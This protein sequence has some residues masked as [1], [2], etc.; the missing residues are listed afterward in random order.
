MAA[1]SHARLDGDGG[2]SGDPTEIALLAAAAGLGEAVDPARREAIRA[3]EFRF[4]PAL[5]LMSTIDRYPGALR[6]HTKGAP[7]AVLPVCAT[8]C[9]ADGAV[10]ALDPATGRELSGVVDAYAA[11]GLRVLAFAARTTLGQI[12]APGSPAGKHFAPAGPTRPR[13]GRAGGG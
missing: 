8:I 7:E 2:A 3:A 10:R 5:K 6:V 11:G 12:M 9:G 1:C 4:D 13:P